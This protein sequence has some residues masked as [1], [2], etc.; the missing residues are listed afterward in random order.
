MEDISIY[1]AWKNGEQITLA[2]AEA[3]GILRPHI[4]PY[5]KIYDEYAK[6]RLAGLN[7][8][9]AVELTAEQQNVSA[10][11]VRRAIGQVV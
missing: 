9:A 5:C 10:E 11:T 3:M 2:Q 4:V 1:Q 8:M 6:H 7:F